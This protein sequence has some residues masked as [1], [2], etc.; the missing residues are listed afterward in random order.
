MSESEMLAA[1]FVG[2]RHWPIGTTLNFGRRGQYQSGTLVA[3]GRSIGDQPMVCV[4]MEGGALRWGYPKDF[5]AYD[6]NPDDIY[7]GRVYRHSTYKGSPAH[8]RGETLDG[9]WSG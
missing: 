9:L 4:R 5:S 7:D 2:M 6:P 3:Y 8:Q 1:P